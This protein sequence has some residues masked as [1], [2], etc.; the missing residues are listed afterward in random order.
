MSTLVNTNDMRNATIRRLIAEGLDYN[1]FPFNDDMVVIPP[2]QPDDVVVIPPLQVFDSPPPNQIMGD[3]EN[4]PSNPRPI[5]DL[6]ANANIVFI[7]RHLVFL[8]ATV[9]TPLR[10]PSERTTTH[11]SLEGTYDSNGY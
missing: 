4:P 10:D 1:S 2:L 3:P 11:R 7:P 9:Q 6:L 5:R 8:G